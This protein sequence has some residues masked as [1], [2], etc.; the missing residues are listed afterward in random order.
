[1][2]LWAALVVFVVLAV[3]CGLAGLFESLD[4]AETGESTR[5]E[6]V[7][8]VAAGICVLIA[9]GITGAILHRLFT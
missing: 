2:S 3:V 4:H 1:M 7:A 9:F 8:M 6:Y 5:A